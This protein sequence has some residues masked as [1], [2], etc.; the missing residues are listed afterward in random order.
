MSFCT[1]RRGK[2]AGEDPPGKGQ[3]DLT[4]ARLISLF[5]STKSGVVAE[6][7]RSLAR[8]QLK[9]EEIDSERQLLKFG[10]G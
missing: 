9:Q 2:H 10:S 6:I 5:K 4:Y 8:G 7:Y 1:F 3:K